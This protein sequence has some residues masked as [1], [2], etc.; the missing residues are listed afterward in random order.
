MIL[1][2]GLIVYPLLFRKGSASFQLYECGLVEDGKKIRTRFESRGT[3]KWGK[4][5][6]I[7]GVDHFW[8]AENSYRIGRH[9][10]EWDQTPGQLR[11]D[12][13]G[14]RNP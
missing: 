10:S 5:V 13:F 4:E 12:M 11:E 7:S 6:V 1:T 14:K 8:F 9:Q 3:T 2:I